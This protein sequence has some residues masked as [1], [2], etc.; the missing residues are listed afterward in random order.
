MNK[1]YYN[2]LGLNKNAS[3][4]EIKRAYRK[5]AIKYHPDK[6]PNNKE[7]EKKFKNCS[8]A[9]QVLSDKNKRKQYDM[10]G[11]INNNINYTNDNNINNN[12]FS[13]FDEMMYEF[14][15]N[16]KGFDFG[17]FHKYTRNKAKKGKEI[18]INVEINFE[19]VMNGCIKN[20]TYKRKINCPD[21]GGNGAKYGTEYSECS[22][23]NGEGQINKQINHGFSSFSY[24]ENCNYCNGTGIKIEENCSKCKGTGKIIDVQN[25]KI[26]IPAGI[27]DGQAIRLSQQGNNGE[28]GG[29]NGDVFCIIKVKEHSLFKRKKNDIYISVPLTISQFIKGGQ[30]TVPT[31]KGN[32]NIDIPNNIT[33]KTV[34]ILYGDGFPSL[35]KSNNGNFIIYFYIEIPDKNKLSKNDK[36]EILNNKILNNKKY[37]N[38][39]NK[40]DKL[41]KKYMI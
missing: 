28:N 22:H 17:N 27:E 38:E 39:I 37:Y 29:P 35:K 12:G 3:Q 26:N 13:F 23:C 4:E 32:K 33:K 36:N 19:D 14:G 10:F 41:S 21:C 16:K 40:Y 30:I 8:E 20:I 34:K 15:F 9:Y 24:V 6:N 31:L 25:N 1:N 5:L 18:I 11:T 2:I 7:A